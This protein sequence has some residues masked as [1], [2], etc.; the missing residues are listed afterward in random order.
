MP[1]PTIEY[2]DSYN[3]KFGNEFILAFLTDGSITQIA[4]NGGAT[5][6]VAP[7]NTFTAGQPFLQMVS[8]GLNGEVVVAIVATGPFLD[9]GYFIWD[10]TNFYK[11]GTASPVTDILDGGS[12]YTSVPA[13]S[14][15]TGGGGAGVAL[16]ASISLGAVDKVTVANPGFGF[17]V[18]DHA[19]LIFSG[20][21]QGIT[22]YGLGD[23]ADGV[24]TSITVVNGGAGYTQVP[25]IIIT[26][27]GGGSG[28]TAIV[29][30]VAGGVIQTV[31]VLSGGS[32]YNLGVTITDDGFGPPPTPA[33]NQIAAQYKAVV[34]NGVITGV[35]MVGVGS[36][37]SSPPTINY[38]SSSGS[39][40]GGVPNL[41]GDT[42]QGV[43]FNFPSQGGSGY[44][45]PVVV[46]FV[47]GGGPA[48]GTLELMPFGVKGNAIET[49][50]SRIWILDGNR[51]MFS[52]P[53]SIV[54]FGDGGGEFQSVDGSLR[55]RFERL[56]SLNGFLYI[57]G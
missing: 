6:Q 14:A 28:A 37:Y 8:V 47:G 32:G 43:T 33:V 49:Y 13:V 44:T 35:Q 55:Y 9:N 39:G 11:A 5:V 7:P 12:N 42:I 36:G 16:T 25:N 48:S 21:G 34:E 45:A 27:V 19:I 29:T 2:F 15:F 17:T 41:V 54:D 46:Q 30:G 3:D 57:I 24:L 4:V 52:A 20:G 23:L 18:F 22:A 1:A 38:L 31:Q 51:I 53:Q 10:G 26:P 50:Q 40:A 56:V